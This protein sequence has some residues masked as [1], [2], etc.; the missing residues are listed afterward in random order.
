MQ[1]IVNT[2]YCGGEDDMEREKQDPGILREL[3]KIAIGTAV[4]FG[5]MMA[6]YAAV[7]RFSLAVLIGGL[8]G[9]VYAV[10]NLYMLGRGVQKAVNSGDEQ[11]ARAGL[12]ASYSMRMV[13]MLVVAV[14]AF[15]LPFAEGVPCLIALLFPRITIFVLQMAGKRAGA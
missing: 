11:M 15:A 7:G 2:V 6:V 5:C 10:L 4:L 12:R 13:G 14:L 1:I 8:L 9:S 3:R